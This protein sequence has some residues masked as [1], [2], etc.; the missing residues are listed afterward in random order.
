M[1]S[2]KGPHFSQAEP[3]WKRCRVGLAGKLVGRLVRNGKGPRILALEGPRVPRA[4]RHYFVT[5]VRS[6]S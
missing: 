3:S 2:A 4:T 6:V 5:S 1:H